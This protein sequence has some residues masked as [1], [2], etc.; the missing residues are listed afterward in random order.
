M[1]RKISDMK[2]I[3]FFFLFTP[4]FANAQN[5]NLLVEG[6]S[7]NLYVNHKVA[8]KENFY[9]IGRIYNISPRDIAP[10]N[11]LELESGLSLGQNLKIP[12]NSSNF[13]QSGEAEA[14]E[15]F[16]PVYYAVKDKEGLYR[17]AQ[18][19]NGLPLET[20]K[21]WNNIKDDAVNKG[22]VLIVGYLKVSNE[23]SAL[24]KNGMGSSI[25]SSAAAVAK[26]ENKPVVT[27]AKTEVKKIPEPVVVAKKE[28]V[29][30]I[31]P[32][33]PDIKPEKKET[34]KAADV[35]A[36]KSNFRASKNLPGGIFKSVYESQI[37]SVSAI[38]EEGTA[39]VFKSTSGWVDRKFYC[40]HN[41]AATGSIVKITNP[42]N[43]KFVYAKVLDII[44][45]I[46]QNT[47][48]VVVVS[49]SA[50]DELGVAETD[51]SCKVSY[52]K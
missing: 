1:Q 38:E 8:P 10:F 51:F 40:L 32:V 46:K 26:T 49:N 42:E 43:G 45:D 28:E 33:A 4:F 7:P 29:S 13:F 18:N 11:K 50:A 47:G 41:N 35:P 22:A 2:K 44:P 20:L 30:N 9:S 39:G 12:L 27:E 37:V 16:V 52:I 24:A 48:Q 31:K 23:L 19:H 15:T 17:V 25:T 5:K 6:V 3:L 36:A 14:G 34:T 21:K